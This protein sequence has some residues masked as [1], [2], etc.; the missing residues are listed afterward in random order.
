MV[1]LGKEAETFHRKFEVLFKLREFTQI[2]NFFKK[3]NFPS[4]LN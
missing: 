4:I 1:I 3:Q 2:Y